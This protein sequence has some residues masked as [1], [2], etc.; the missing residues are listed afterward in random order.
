MQKNLSYYLVTLTIGKL[1]ILFYQ[2]KLLALVINTYMF[3][4]Y[5]VIKNIDTAWSTNLQNN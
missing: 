2:I 5:A 3:T 1:Q 4:T